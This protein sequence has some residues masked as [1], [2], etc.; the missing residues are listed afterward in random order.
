MVKILFLF[1]V[2]KKL[3]SSHFQGPTS[4]IRAGGLKAIRPESPK[5]PKG[6]IWFL[7]VFVGYST[8]F[9]A[10]GMISVARDPRYVKIG[11]STKQTQI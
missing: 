11:M 9:L 6:T 8:Q 3:I 5:D 7:A 2:D 1:R 10:P 4:G